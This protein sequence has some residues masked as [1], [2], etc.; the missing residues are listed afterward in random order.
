[1]QKITRFF[2]ITPFLSIIHGWDRWSAG[3]A[4]CVWDLNLLPIEA[5]Q[6]WAFS[7]TQP[8]LMCISCSLPIGGRGLLRDLVA[9]AEGSGAMCPGASRD[10][11]VG[12][13]LQRRSCKL[14]HDWVLLKRRSNSDALKHIFQH[15][16]FSGRA[17]FSL[18]A[19]GYFIQAPTV[20]SSSKQLIYLTTFIV[21][22]PA[23]A[24]LSCPHIALP[25]TIWYALWH[26]IQTHRNA[27]WMLQDWG[28]S[29]TCWISRRRP[30]FTSQSACHGTRSWHFGS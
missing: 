15:K 7:Q 30:G 10:T 12:C 20:G 26:P 23:G 27:K 22:R 9:Y 14:L 6:L 8:L 24:Q 2:L 16:P 5:H 28:K 4:P 17:W 29:R 13:Q 21:K 18:L 3:K 1:M 11:R 25:S 19:L